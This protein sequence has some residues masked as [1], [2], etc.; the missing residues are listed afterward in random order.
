MIRMWHICQIQFQ[1]ECQYICQVECRKRSDIIL[2]KLSEYISKYMSWNVIGGITWSKV[3][4][5]YLFISFYIFFLFFIY[6]YIVFLAKKMF[7][8]CLFC[9]FL[10]Q[11]NHV[12]SNPLR[13]AALLSL[14]EFIAE[15]N[16]NDVHVRFIIFD[17]WSIWDCMQCLSCL[18]VIWC[19]LL[20]RQQ[21]ERQCHPDH[22]NIFFQNVCP[23]SA[24]V[25]NLVYCKP[26]LPPLSHR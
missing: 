18:V 7:F 14:A 6:L 12:V 25:V 9:L 1:I 2:G 16:E 4:P 23:L 22:L 17:A 21:Q 24:T 20:G 8:L 5:F 19:A 3:I 11:Q 26:A 10:D 15:M 13:P